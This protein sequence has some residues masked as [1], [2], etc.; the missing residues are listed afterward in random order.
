MMIITDLIGN[1][2][3]GAT[4][5]VAIGPFRV[6]PS[7]FAKPFFAVICAWLLTLWR[8]GEN[9][10]GW[11]WATALA[12]TIVS[13]IQVPGW[14][15]RLALAQLSITSLKFLLTVTENAFFL[16]MKGI[17]Q[18]FLNEWGLIKTEHTLIIFC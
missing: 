2:V 18:K 11:V 1:E 12:A 10:P 7:E 6:Q 16:K 14:S 3:N 13:V 9:F 8:D 15:F 5:W 4:R 17:F